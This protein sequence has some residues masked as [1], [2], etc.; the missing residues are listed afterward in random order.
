MAKH[1]MRGPESRDLMHY[2]LES[3]QPCPDYSSSHASRNPPGFKGETGWQFVAQADKIKEVDPHV[4]MIEMVENALYVNDG[5]EVKAVL[6]QLQGMYHLHMGVLPV[7]IIIWRLQQQ[8]TIVY[9]W[10]Q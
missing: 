3:G 10:F 5:D 9:H 8:A 7:A 4:S 2:Y 6:S 1:E